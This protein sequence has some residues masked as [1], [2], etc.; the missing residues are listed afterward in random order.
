MPNRSAVNRGHPCLISGGTKKH[1]DP[2]EEVADARV[3]FVIG[4]VVFVVGVVVSLVV[5]QAWTFAIGG[6]GIVILLIANSL[7]IRGQTDMSTGTTTL[8]G[9]VEEKKDEVHGHEQGEDHRYSIRVGGIKFNVSEEMYGKIPLHM[10]AIV[11]YYPK[12]EKLIAIR[13]AERPAR[14]RVAGQADRWELQRINRRAKIAE[15]SESGHTMSFEWALI[16]GRAGT[17]KRLIEGGEGPNQVFE[18]DLDPLFLAMTTPAG[19]GYVETVRELLAGGA[20]PNSAVE[21]GWS[22][23]LIAVT[24]GSPD[25]VRSLL[26]AGADP[27]A[28]YVQD[29]QDIT[30]ITLARQKNNQEIVDIFDSWGAGAK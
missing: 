26:E 11:T 17:V 10:E 28:T 4:A 24:E 27:T 22:P 5:Q 30:P 12:S 25:F 2:K 15:E 19:T 7:W 18:N 16:L 21:G 9:T 14:E 8:Q 13:P 20:N 6:L 29:G 3:V 1:S 23:L